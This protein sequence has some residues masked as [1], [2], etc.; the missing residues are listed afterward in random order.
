MTG[1]DAHILGSTRP[2]R[3]LDRVVS[4]RQAVDGMSPA[5]GSEFG[6]LV[7]LYRR[8]RGLTQEELAEKA[9]LSVRAISD[10]ERGLKYRPR[11]DTVQLLVEA[12]ELT[13]E[14]REAFWRA[15]R[16]IGKPD[17][18]SQHGS[19]ETPT[20]LQDEPTPFIGREREVARLVHLLQQPK[21]RL[22][23]LTGPGGTG[24]TRLALEVAA[25]RLN[26]FEDGVYLVSLAPLTDPTL[27][28]PAIAGTLGITDTG[29]QSLLEAMTDKRLLLVLDNFEHLLGAAPLVRD[30][31]QSCP[32]VQIL[33]TSREIL[34]LSAER[35]FPVPPLTVPDLN[36][37]QDLQAL[38][39]YDAVALFVDRAQAA[40][41]DFV[42]TRDNASSIAA[43]CHRLD[44]LP[45]ALEL[46]AARIRLFPPQALLGRVS[47]G[48]DLLTGGARD[49]PARQQTLRG[50]IDWSYSLL[51]PEEQTL[52]ARL[53]VFMGGC[54]P[55]AAEVVCT[56]GADWSITA[57][58][59]LVSLIQKSLLRQDGERESRFGMLQTIQ[60]YAVEKLEERGEAQEVRRRHAL[61]FLE[62]AEAIRPQ[63]DGPGQA[64][65]LNRLE[66]EHNNLRVAVGWA[67]DQGEIELGLRLA[68]ASE[69]LYMRGHRAEM[70]R[71][72]EKL[73]TVETAKGNHVNPSL[74]AVALQLA[75]SYASSVQGNTDRA[76]ALTEESIAL[77][78]QLRDTREIAY[79]LQGAGQ[80]LGE[81]GDDARAIAVL[82]QALPMFKELD[83]KAGVGVVLLDLAN[84][85]RARGEAARVIKLCEESLPLCREVG[86]T[87][88]VSYALHNLGVAAW[89][90]GDLDR[91]RV[92][93]EEALE[94][95]QQIGFEA[96]RAEML[97]SLAT[98]VRDQGDL[99][100]AEKLLAEGLRLCRTGTSRAGATA[101]SLE[102]MA[103]VAAARSRVERA[104]AL[105]GAVHALR[106]R[107]GSSIWPINRRHSERDLVAARQALGAARFTKAW[108][109]GRAMTEE[110]AID[111]AL[112]ER[113]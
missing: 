106:E 56:A 9:T 88:Y 81:Q 113:P 36:Q 12:L 83:D 98:I 1:R 108:E 45:L 111:Y 112:V 19:P 91:A 18:I 105:F 49:R 75:A 32:S 57:V 55:D 72:F 8:D 102:G 40:R 48:L 89:M 39:Q 63:L 110:Q 15:A 85:A 68:I 31:I 33:V 80:L 92:L 22:I 30:L 90:L 64:E 69:Y 94:L 53:S 23:T 21:A 93:C 44:G 104:G 51:S 99:D 58:D 74:R 2:G 27:V 3:R 95:N 47:R 60:E 14:Q 10:L 84:I 82:E 41:P 6:D 35:E 79:R 109:E 66:Q 7:R 73:L 67:C 26:A 59:G 87:P 77:I 76:R 71:W 52:V 107:T 96:E 50:T 101:V 97:D 5:Q 37:T 86:N 78:G 100:Q 43:I 24:K 28:A 11:K 13:D 38:A 46:A 42:L 20:N 4:S 34:H 25:A 65:G 29:E 16:G 62:C 103:G 54:T 61:Y 17:R 70:S